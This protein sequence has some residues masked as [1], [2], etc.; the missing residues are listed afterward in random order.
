M[1]KLLFF[2]LFLLIILLGVFIFPKKN[3]VSAPSYVTTISQ[4]FCLPKNIETN[5]SFEGGAGNIYGSVTIKNVSSK[6]CDIQ[7]DKFISAKF[8]APNISISQQGKKGSALLHLQPGQTVYSQI[9][10]PNGPQCNGSTHQT[11][12]N[13]N[14]EISPESVATFVQN[15]NLPTTNVTTCDGKNQL[16]QIDVWSISLTPLH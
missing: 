7:G 4:N 8:S 11:A 6:T 2:I 3:P 16:T 5:V 10:F 1:R 13:F 15:G 12:V 9:H 14:Y